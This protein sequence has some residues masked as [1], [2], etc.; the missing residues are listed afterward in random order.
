M[1]GSNEQRWPPRSFG[2]QSRFLLKRFDALMVDD[3]H[4]EVF[5]DLLIRDGS[6]H[7]PAFDW[8][9]SAHFAAFFL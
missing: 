8:Q 5:L 9:S 1:H 6:H 7:A 3:G 4:N 2:R